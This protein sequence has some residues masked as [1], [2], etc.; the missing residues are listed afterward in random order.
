MWGDAVHMVY[1]GM[2]EGRMGRGG[3]ERGG[4]ARAEKHCS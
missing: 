2:E 4:W 1:S 3:E